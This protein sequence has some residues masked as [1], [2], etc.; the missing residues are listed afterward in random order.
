MNWE[1]IAALAEVAGA[2]GV[3]ASLLYLS[4]QIGHNTRQ[5]TIAAHDGTTRNFREFIRQTLAGGYSK[6]FSDGLEDFESLD[7]QGKLDFTFLMFDMFKA[8][9]NVHYHYLY[10]SMAEDAWLAWKR[11][12]TSYAVAP[13]AQQYWKI[14][15][16]VY[17][18]EF[19]ELVDGLDDDGD[20]K[21]VGHV[22]QEST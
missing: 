8:F 6:V 15:R 17:T 5:M 14:R 4:G 11:L 12:L 13:G 9:E 18:T 20:L 22:R 1:A 16:D 19:R 21:R 2:V 7:E 10:G 3:I